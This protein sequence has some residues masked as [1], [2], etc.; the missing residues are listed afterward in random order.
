MVS[1]GCGARSKLRVRGDEAALLAP[2]AEVRAGDVL[3]HL[4]GVLVVLA[5][6]AGQVAAAHD[7]RS[8]RPRSAGAGRP[9]RARR[10]SAID[11]L[12]EAAR[13]G[14]EARLPVQEALWRVIEHRVARGAKFVLAIALRPPSTLP[15]V[16][17]ILAISSPRLL[18][19]G[20]LNGISCLTHWS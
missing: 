2:A 7:R 12:R 4:H 5:E 14:E 10:G 15:S 3:Q 9:R 1:L 19:H 6:Q 11:V 16:N 18:D 20:S 17:Q 13:L 8:R